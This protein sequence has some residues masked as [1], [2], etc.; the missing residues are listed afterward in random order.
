MRNSESTYVFISSPFRGWVGINAKEN[1]GGGGGG[2]LHGF[3]FEFENYHSL[4]LGNP[5]VQSV[6]EI[7][8]MEHTV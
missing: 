2:G 4:G 8:L 1:W 3:F 7:S 5:T 6:V